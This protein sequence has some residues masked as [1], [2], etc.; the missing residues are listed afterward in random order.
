[1]KNKYL[2]T[3]KF[4]EA[5][6]TFAGL[7]FSAQMKTF[8]AKLLLH[9]VEK[10]IFGTCTVAGGDLKTL[11]DFEITLSDFN[12][13][14]PSYMGIKVADKVKVSVLINKFNVIKK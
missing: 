6:L 9:G 7:P 12:I 2:E 8:K 10:E 3:A 1:M 11:A 4:P 13:E 14:I 5:K